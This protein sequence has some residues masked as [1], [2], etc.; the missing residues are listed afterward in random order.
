MLLKIAHNIYTALRRRP[1]R[2]R[3]A[4]E[5]FLFDATDLA[6]FERRQRTWHKQDYQMLTSLGHTRTWN[7]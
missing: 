5:R 7:H 2:A 1:T 4:E 3:T 6:D